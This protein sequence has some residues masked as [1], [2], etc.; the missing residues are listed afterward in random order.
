VGLAPIDPLGSGFEA[1][2]LHLRL[3]PGLTD[4]P[5]VQDRPRILRFEAGLLLDLH[6]RRLARLSGAIDRALALRLRRLRAG[7][8]YVRLGFA[9]F[10]DY[11]RERLGVA[12]RTGQELSRL[13][14]GLAR[15]PALDAALAEGRI[16]WTA[17]AEVAR[18]AGAEDAGEWVAAAERL[19]VRALRERVRAA[20]ESTA[21]GRHG[22]GPM[23][24]ECDHGSTTAG[25]GSTAP[26]AGSNQVDPLA[27]VEPRPRT[28]DASEMEDP[29]QTLSVEVDP[30]TVHLWEAALDLCEMVAGT[31]LGPEEA[32]EFILADFLSGRPEVA[33]AHP[34]IEGS[35]PVIHGWTRERALR[36][37]AAVRSRQSAEQLGPAAVPEGFAEELKQLEDVLRA[38]VPEDPFE[39]DLSMRRLVARRS[40]LDLDL[41]RLLRNFSSLRLAQHLGFAGLQAYVEERLGIS[42]RRASRLVG[43]DRRIFFFREIARAVRNGAI[44][45]EAAW[46]LF[47]VATP[48]ATESVWIERAR[49]RTVARLRE[50]VRWVIREGRRGRLGALWMPPPHGR[51]SSALEEISAEL[52]TPTSAG[53]WRGRVGDESPA[54]DAPTSA[55]PPPVAFEAPNNDATTSCDD[56]ALRAALDAFSRRG[57]VGPR[58]RV[59]FLLRESAIGLWTEARKRI[60]AESRAVWVPDAEVLRCVAIEFLATYLPLWF[61]EVREGDPVAVRDRFRCQVPGCTVRGGAAHHLRYRSQLGPDELWNLLFVCYT[62]HILGEHRRRIR[63]SGRVGERVVFELGLKPDGTA[64]ENFVNEERSLLE[65]G[66]PVC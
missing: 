29:I 33:S 17:A 18:V 5:F 9:L 36:A 58:V 44:G 20:L 22:G 65:S 48:E 21:G 11:V 45:T 3:P 49:R 41:A 24:A 13:G 63:I 16:T 14:E 35:P 31:D 1:A 32:P 43:L 54:E 8:G 38:P 57:E 62:H 37:A 23:S 42:A 10:R 59:D 55:G 4:I 25:D 56:L 27:A 53:A 40:A 39:I 47:K 19:T 66:G 52:L 50:E 7:R 60:D 61:Q 64:L 34:P 15:L 12:E 51:L 46:E 30:T 2:P 6:L 26:D 28:S